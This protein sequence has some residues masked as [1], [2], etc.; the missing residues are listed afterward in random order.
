MYGSQPLIPNPV[1]ESDISQSPPVTPIFSQIS[2]SPTSKSFIANDVPHTKPKPKISFALLALLVY[3]VGVKCRGINKKEEYAA[4]H[5]FS[6]SEN[7]ANKMLRL[8][9]W[10]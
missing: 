10:D 3:T 5:M 8:N 2:V 1:S 7:T 4:E 6:L 9:M